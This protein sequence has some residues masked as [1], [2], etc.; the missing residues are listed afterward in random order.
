MKRF[1]L[2]SL[3]S[4]LSATAVA[5]S[6]HLMVMGGGGEP[7]GNP[8]TIFDAELAS[9]G[10]FAKANPQWEPS[11]IFDGGHAQTEAI[12]TQHFGRFNPA[13]QTFSSKN[14]EA[15]I[16]LY[17]KRLN[18]GEI[19]GGDK[20]LIHINSHGALR[21]AK[22]EET[23]RISTSDAAATNLQTLG[24]VT[25][26]LDRLK[27]LSELAARKGVKLGIVDLSCHSGS[28]L[29]L[30]NANTCVISATGP[31]HYSYGGGSTFSAKFNQAMAKGKS[32]EEV[33]LTARSNYADT[34]FPMIS[35]P[36]GRDVQ[37]RLYELLTPYLYYFDPQSDK[38]TKY[39]EREVQSPNTCAPQ[40]DLKELVT[41]VEELL[42]TV[43]GP[44]T[45]RELEYFKTSVT[46][47]FN[48]LTKTRAEMRAAG[49]PQA[50]E[51]V[52]F[53][54][55]LKAPINRRGARTRECTEYRVKDLVS[56]DIDRVQA[57]F[58]DMSRRSKGEEA[59]IAQAI[60]ENLDQARKKKAELLR[61]NP[62]LE[63]LADFWASNPGRRQETFTLAAHV[64]KSHQRLFEK[65]YRQSP[66]TG[67]NPCRDFVL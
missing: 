20:L 32:L 19:K 46:N 44:D 66:A 12:V 42:K 41:L 56:L 51:R 38:H 21:D 64:S 37:A 27:K 8:S 36:Q 5:Q 52:S 39:L 34:S 50:M 43:A 61:Q 2:T 47:Y 59:L 1:I 45:K 18:S 15:L 33:F 17:E 30:A 26:P 22:G 55:N 67:P 23:H 63:K 58:R 40:E 14:Y 7:K 48:Y 62:R 29:N 24:G 53:C 9:L 31:E 35:T 49:F 28:T 10:A 4:I 25:V 11:V 57:H 6:N 65:L 16:A 54:S 3:F 13:G 60:S